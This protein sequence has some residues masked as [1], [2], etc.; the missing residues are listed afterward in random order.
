MRCSSSHRVASST[1]RYL[2]LWHNVQSISCLMQV[3][4]FPYSFVP[5][6]EKKKKKA[7]PNFGQS[8][9]STKEIPLEL[10][11]FMATVY[12]DTL[13]LDPSTA[14]S[15]CSKYQPYF[16]TTELLQSFVQTEMLAGLEVLQRSL[17]KLSPC[18]SKVIY[19]GWVMKRGKMY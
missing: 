4:F 10:S 17:N 13:F 18:P 6:N 11:V 15:N 3:T 16:I 8:A 5:S 2:F 9:L 19:E 12:N 14:T 7:L 1:C